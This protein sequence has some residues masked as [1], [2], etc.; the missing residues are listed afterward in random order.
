[1]SLDCLYKG[2]YVRHILHIFLTRIKCEIMFQNENAIHVNIEIIN[3]LKKLFKNF[4]PFIILLNANQ[5][6]IYAS[7]TFKNESGNSVILYFLLCFIIA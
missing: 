2:N 4:N 7:Y 3:E 5:N 6:E 1:M